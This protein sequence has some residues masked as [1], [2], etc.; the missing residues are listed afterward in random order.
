M[1]GTYEKGVKGTWPTRRANR[2]Y[3]EALDALRAGRPSRAEALLQA[4]LDRTP[5]AAQSVYLLGVALL[6][7]GRTE[8]ARSV[9]DEAYLIKP[10][11]RDVNPEDFDVSGLAE[12]AVR[13]APDW[14][15]PRYE[16][17]RRAFF[18][19]GLTLRQV[20]AR[21]LDRDDVYFIEVGANDGIDHDPI[22]EHVIRHG[23]SGV[24]V[25][26]LPEPYAKLQ[27]TYAGVPGVRCLQAAISDVVGEATMHVGDNTKLASL[28][29]D[30]NALTRQSATSTFTV[31]TTTFTDVLGAA[32]NPRVD[33]LQIDTEGYDWHVLRTFDLATHGPVVINME[34]YCLPLS[35]RISTF[36][37]LR[38]H[39]YAYRFDGMD[40][41][42]VRREQADR[43]FLLHDLTDGRFLPGPS[44]A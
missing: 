15:W 37:L 44:V 24:C 33:V 38:Q 32:G 27:Q 3:A 7:Q 6:A 29:P 4:V 5:R 1:G 43:R 28:V 12:E 20:V 19:V 39:G 16:I 11:L 40:L 31:P 34:F 13:E 42:A 26:P 10:W 8:L 36:A 21:H 9:I 30:R 14:I 2:R 35:E 18:S 23:W 41:L 22:H 25:E 17:E